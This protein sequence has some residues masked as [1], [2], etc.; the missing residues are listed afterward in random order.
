M[1]ETKIDY[2]NHKRKYL[3]WKEKAK[4]GIEGLSLENYNVLMRYLS[5]MES[6]LNVALLMKKGPRSFIRLNTL[7]IRMTFMMRLFQTRY[8]LDDMTLV[9]EETRQDIIGRLPPGQ[10]KYTVRQMVTARQD[11]MAEQFK[12]TEP[13][14]PLRFYYL[15]NLP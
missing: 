3:S 1:I 15:G 5:D 8:N 6:G 2:Y 11:Y 9:D 12:P 13:L 4:K 14:S 7:R 10:E